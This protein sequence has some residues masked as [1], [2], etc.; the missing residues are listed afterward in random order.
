MAS[1][2]LTHRKVWEFDMDVSLA[3]ATTSAT[4]LDDLYRPRSD[5]EAASFL[6]IKPATLQT[7]RRESR[8]TGKRQGPAW[9]DLAGFGSKPIPRY[10]LID[11]IAWQDSRLTVLEPARKVGR[12][13]KAVAP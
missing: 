6:G 3:S 9:I 7:W 12:P 8:R 1:V 11:L 5:A 4:S 2:E 10:R 13:R